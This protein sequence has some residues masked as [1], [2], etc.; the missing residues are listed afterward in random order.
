MNSRGPWYSSNTCVIWLVEE[1]PTP[2]DPN[3]YL[4][5]SN[6]RSALERMGYL[7]EERTW[8]YG[9]ENQIAQQ[10]LNGSTSATNQ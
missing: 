3:G 10:K 5:S 9:P 8:C 7:G 1:I 4:I 2:S 6:I